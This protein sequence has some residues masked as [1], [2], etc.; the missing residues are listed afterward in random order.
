MIS[1][2]SALTFLLLNGLLIGYSLLMKYLSHF[3]NMFLL[4]ILKNFSLIYVLEFATRN[5]K[6][7]LPSIDKSKLY[8]NRMQLQRGISIDNI[9][10]DPQPDYFGEFE[11]NVARASL[12]EYLSYIIISYLLGFQT[13]SVLENLLYFIPKSFIFELMFDFFHYITHRIVHS[14]PYLYKSLHKTHHKFRFPTCITAY[15]QDPLDLLLTNCLPF[16]LTSYFV[17][18][19]YYEF[20][21]YIIYKSFL[22]IVGHC[23]KETGSSC[24]TQFFWLPK[25]FGIELTVRDHDLHHTKNNCNYAKRFSLWDKIFGTYHNDIEKVEIINDTSI[26]L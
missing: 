3:Y 8:N 26:D 22:E 12:I 5:K 23:G 7:I 25:F 1:L 10:I 9:R 20:I 11:F 15:Y 21:L 24:F 14:V 2:K 6:E 19:S 17:P 4:I 18:L 13:T 16:V